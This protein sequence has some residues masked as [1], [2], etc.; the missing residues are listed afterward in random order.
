MPL[1]DYSLKIIA[2]KL[3]EIGTDS[4]KTGKILTLSYPDIIASPETV[5]EIFGERAAGLPIREDSDKTIRWHKA[6]NITTQ[7]VDT[8][9]L[10][11]ALGYTL[12]VFDRHAGRGGEIL[13]DLSEQVPNQERYTNQYDLVFD[14]I[15]NQC[16]NVAQVWW[17]MVQCCR[18]DGYIL[19][20]TPMQ[21]VN[22]GFWNVSPAAY[23]DFAVANGLTLTYEAITGVYAQIAPTLKLDTFYRQRGVPDDTMNVALMQ[24][25]SALPFPVW[26]IMSKFQ[27][28]P[29][30]HLE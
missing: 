2:N 9:A 4:A 25:T 14:C 23:R 13:C 6:N 10:F 26:P 21:M 20:V 12:D 28:Y 16:F 17:T 24:K 29:K 11:A 19:S 30:S 5:R 27:K 8:K 22:Q 7:I 1:V 3:K 18:V 15:S